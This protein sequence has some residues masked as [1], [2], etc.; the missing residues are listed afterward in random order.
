[1]VQLPLLDAGVVLQGAAVLLNGP[2]QLIAPHGGS[3]I[4]GIG[5]PFGSQLLVQRLLTRPQQSLA[6]ALARQPRSIRIV[7]IQRTPQRD[8]QTRAPAAP[9]SL[10]DPPAC[11][12]CR[13]D[14]W[15]AADRPPAASPRLE[16]SP[17]PAAAASTA[18]SRSA[19]TASG[20]PPARSHRTPASSSRPLPALQK[21]TVNSF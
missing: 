21:T 16:K 5:L 19:A 6:P 17:P 9:S 7:G 11:R 3:G 4:V 15:T 20:H 14:H 13:P 1:M 12:P 2:A 10:D 8:D 18:P